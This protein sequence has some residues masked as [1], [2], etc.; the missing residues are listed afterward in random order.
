M[1]YTIVLSQLKGTKGMLTYALFPKIATDEV[2]AAGA[3]ALGRALVF[4]ENSLAAGGG[5]GFLVHSRP[6]IAGNLSQF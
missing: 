1:I 5:S 6:T 3:K 2:K 4:M